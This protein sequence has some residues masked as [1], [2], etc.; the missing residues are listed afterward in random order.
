[1]I[2][3]GIQWFSFVT[4]NITYGTSNDCHVDSDITCYSIPM[5]PRR[6]TALRKHCEGCILS[7]I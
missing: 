1:M 6:L 3:T 5:T 7:K 4:P 2:F